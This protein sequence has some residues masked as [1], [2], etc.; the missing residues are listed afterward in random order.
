MGRNNFMPRA[1]RTSL[2]HRKAE[3]IKMVRACQQ[4]TRSCEHYN[5]RNSRWQAKQRKI[6]KSLNQQHHKLDRK[7]YTEGPQIVV[8]PPE[9]EGDFERLLSY[10][11]HQGH[12]IENSKLC[13]SISLKTL[14]ITYSS[15]I[16]PASKNAYLCPATEST[17]LHFNP[18]QA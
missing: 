6:K 1:A 8:R 10:C 14:R 16:A 9:M 2:E 4:I 17:I 13:Q 15:S 7:I 12:G 3:E 5:A 11:V 18:F